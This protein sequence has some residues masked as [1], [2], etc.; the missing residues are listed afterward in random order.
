[1]LGHGCGNKVRLFWQK[2]LSIGA[3]AEMGQADTSTCAHAAPPLVSRDNVRI[4][5]LNKCRPVA[6]RNRFY[7]GNRDVRPGIQQL[8]VSLTYTFSTF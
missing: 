2:P 7:A 6:D 5:S 3:S 4:D 1:M 8:D